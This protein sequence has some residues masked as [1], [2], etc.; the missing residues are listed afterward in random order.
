MSGKPFSHLALQTQNFCRFSTLLFTFHPLLAFKAPCLFLR[1]LLPSFHSICSPPHLTLSF[2]S[3]D[4]SHNT[5]SG[6]TCERNGVRPH[7]TPIDRADKSGC[8][9]HLCTPVGPV[10]AAAAAAASPPP[11]QMSCRPALYATVYIGY[12]VIGY[13]VKLL[14]W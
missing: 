13:M 2:S 11:Q 6:R 1:S 4:V 14:I 3:V 12:M 9:L 10:V 5:S 8:A 7:R